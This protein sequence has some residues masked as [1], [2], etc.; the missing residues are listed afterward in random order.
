MCV[1]HAMMCMM[2]AKCRRRDV[3]HSILARTRSGTGTTTTSTTSTTCTRSVR[4]EKTLLQNTG[5]TPLKIPAGRWYLLKPVSGSTLKNIT[6][7]GPIARKLL[8]DFFTFG[9]L[10]TCCVLR[11]T[12]VEKYHSN[13][14]P[15]LQ[16]LI[17][18]QV[19]YCRVG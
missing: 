5:R 18:V 19:E 4:Y 1:S 17:A 2:K 6:L 13:A 3:Y 8:N 15:V 11:K 12:C 7:K 16:Y 10:L 9:S 14:V